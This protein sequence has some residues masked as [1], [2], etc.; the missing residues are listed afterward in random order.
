LKGREDATKESDFTY[1]DEGEEDDEE[2]DWDGE[3]EWTEGDE[4]EGAAEGDVPDES[5]AYL[6]FL[7]QEVSASWFWS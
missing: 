5:A 6:D 4:L 7:N 1:D 2:N 3:V